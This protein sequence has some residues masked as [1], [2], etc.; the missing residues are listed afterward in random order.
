[1]QRMIFF[2]TGWMERYE[3]G[4][5]YGGGSYITE[6]GYG[7]EIYNFKRIGG[8][9]YGY[10]QPSGANNLERLG[11]RSGA[12]SI[13]DILI[14]FTATHE[15]GGTYIV[16]WYKNATFYREYQNTRMKER[17]YK[18]E[19]IG[20]YAEA[21]SKDAV[22]LPEDDRFSFPS[23]P[24]YVKGGMGRSNIWY[25][26][27]PNMEPFRFKVLKCI[28]DYESRR[29]KHTRK[30]RGRSYTADIE[31]KKN[32]EVFAVNFVTK[33]YESR[34]FSVSSV[35]KDNCGW[36]LEARFKKVRYRLEVKGLSSNSIA[37]ELSQNE[38]DKMLKH[39]HQ[40]RLCIVTGCL[41]KEPLLFIFSYSK[42]QGQW[43]DE[44]GNILEIEPRISA[45]C[46][47][48]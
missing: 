42:E 4:S 21:E 2:N 20:Y 35:E 31:H 38:Y 41:T 14:I 17:R 32:V 48:S 11:A 30:K 22:L 36:D 47:L 6:Y 44:Q 46:Y 10:A 34:G 39:K 16:G 29:N 18:R 13:S 1:M 37:V 15:Q 5:I 3:G 12:D 19:Y 23:I 7:H 26:D 45:R 9:V 40:Y 28:N 43:I 25:A 27:S 24:R 33:E 8:K